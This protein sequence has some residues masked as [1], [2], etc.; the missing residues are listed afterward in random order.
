[1]NGVDLV[2]EAKMI[3]NDLKEFK[4]TCEKPY[5]RHS[6]RLN[7]KNGKSVVFEDYELMR[8]H[9]YQ[10]RDNVLGVDVIEDEAGKGF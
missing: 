6:Y 4:L 8:Y 3:N 5:D 10:W 1:M 2:K 9:W 7:L